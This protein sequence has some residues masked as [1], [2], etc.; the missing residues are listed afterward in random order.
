MKRKFGHTRRQQECAGIEERP[1][2]NTARTW[3]SRNQGDRSQETSS[4]PTPQAKTSSLQNAEKMNL[5]CLSHPAC[6]ILL[7]QPQ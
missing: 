3:L 4:L 2:E 6:G 5:Y 7:W 1:C